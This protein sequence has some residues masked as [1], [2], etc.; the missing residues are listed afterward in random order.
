MD[1]NEMFVSRQR[2]SCSRI[3]ISTTR[4]VED[5]NQE[6]QEGKDLESQGKDQSVLHGVQVELIQSKEGNRKAIVSIIQSNESDDGN[7]RLN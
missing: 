5:G 3:L 7:C 2:I 4:D 1:L 6:T